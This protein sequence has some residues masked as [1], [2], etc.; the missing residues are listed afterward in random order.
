MKK[1]LLEEILDMKTEES[2]DGMPIII[3]P[4]HDEDGNI[5]LYNAVDL[6]GNGKYVD[7]KTAKEN[8]LKKSGNEIVNKVFITRKI[9]GKD[10]TF[11]IRNKLDKHH[12]KRVVAAFLLGP[13]WQ[14]RDWPVQEKPATLF[15]KSIFE[16]II[17]IVR[18]FYL[19]Y[20]EMPPNPNI[21]H[22]NVKILTISKIRRY[23]D[24]GVQTDFWTE[25]EKFIIAPRV[26]I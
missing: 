4:S 26:K 7:P 24:Q 16:K 18:A 14:F 21:T 11:E 23:L 1:S 15:L 20:Q 19:K 9:K 8:F 13:E 12:W 6:L 10:V 5:N 22:W 17:L 3:V 2:T 25:L